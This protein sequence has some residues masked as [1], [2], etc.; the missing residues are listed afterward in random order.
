MD[1]DRPKEPCIRWVAWIPQVMGTIMGD[2]SRPIILG[3]I[4][5]IQHEPKLFGRWHS[6]MTSLT[7]PVI[8][9]GF[10]FIDLADDGIMPI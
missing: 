8:I 1:L 3:S 6:A 10:P 2:I 4:G 5:N 9:T 7:T